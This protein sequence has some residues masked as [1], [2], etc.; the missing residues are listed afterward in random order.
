M[1]AHRPL[2]L[3]SL[4]FA[5]EP[6]WAIG[7]AEPASDNFIRYVCRTL[8]D[9]LHQRFGQQC[10]VIYGGSAGPGLLTRLWPDA[11]GI[12]LGRFSHQPQAVATILD[13][14]LA[15]TARVRGKKCVSDILTDTNL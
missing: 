14:A 10:R 6:Q 7:A 4:I 12:F 9:A 13:E 8:R 3:A 11:D 2:P 5:W 1:L 15:L